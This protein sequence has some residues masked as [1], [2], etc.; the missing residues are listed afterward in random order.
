MTVTSTM[1]AARRAMEL[2]DGKRVSAE[3]TAGR[4]ERVARAMRERRY[5][6]IARPL[7]ACWYHLAIAALE[8]DSE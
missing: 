1:L 5:E 7:A 4:V 6:L 2:R 3:I 8:A